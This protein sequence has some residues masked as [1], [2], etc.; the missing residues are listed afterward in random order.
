MWSA[1]G[2]S[3]AI[4]IGM[5]N[6]EELLA[7]GHDMDNHFRQTPFEKN[8]P[9]VLAL[10]GVWY[11]NFFGA[12][13]HCILPYDQYMHRF[14]AYF[15]QVCHFIFL[16]SFHLRVTWKVTVSRWTEME[17]V[18][19]TQLGP[20]FGESQEPMASMPFISSFTKEPN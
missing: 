20:S 15:Q 17:T 6:F 3:I 9:A 4:F 19:H 8:I 1:I 16:C 18:Y 10:L 11:N 7:G 12:Q 13:T 5:N 2:L 14:P